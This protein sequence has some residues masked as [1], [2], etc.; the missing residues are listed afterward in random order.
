MELMRRLLRK[1]TPSPETTKLELS[2]H[3]DLQD[4]IRAGDADQ[5]GMLMDQ[6]LRRSLERLQEQASGRKET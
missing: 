2:E 4:A 1:R 3:R 6:H 5:A